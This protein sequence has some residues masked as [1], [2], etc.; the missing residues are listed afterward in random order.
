MRSFT[1]V[2]S[3]LFGLPGVVVK[4]SVEKF[5][6]SA[7]QRLEV[8]KLRISKI[9]SLQH[10]SRIKEDAGISGVSGGKLTLEVAEALLFSAPAR[11]VAAFALDFPIN[12]N[13]FELLDLN[14][15]T[16]VAA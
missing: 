7:L 8:N 5:A 13:T 10:S 12:G 3:P 9:W 6:T 15:V 2:A 4:G 16:D 1:R 14:T 11:A